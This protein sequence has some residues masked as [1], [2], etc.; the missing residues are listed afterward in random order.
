MTSNGWLITLIDI[1]LTW[2]NIKLLDYNRGF[3]GKL[4]FRIYDDYTAAYHLVRSV[5]PVE[6]HL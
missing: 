5:P 3:L 2:K 4:N 1:S 6:P